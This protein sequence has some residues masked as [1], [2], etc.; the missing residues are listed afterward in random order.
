LAQKGLDSNIQVIYGDATRVDLPE[1]VDVCVS[2]LFGMIASS[3]GAATILNQARR[4]LKPGGVMIPHRCSTQIAAASL[5]ETLVREPRF[6]EISGPYVER[7]FAQMGSPFD[8]RI[9][10]NHFPKSYLLSSSAV[11]EAMD[12]TD[13]A[14]EQFES[15]IRLTITRRGRLDGF[16]LWLTLDTAPGEH[17]DALLDQVHWLPVFFPAFSPGVE[18]DSGDEIRAICTGAPAAG[19]IMPDYLISGYIQRRYGRTNFCFISSR[20]HSE[21]RSNPFYQALFADGYQKRYTMP[22]ENVNP[23]ALEEHLKGKLP[24][25]MIPSTFV[26]V[27]ELPCTASGKLDRRKLE[28]PART[29]TAEEPLVPRTATER[30]VAGIWADLLGLDAVGLDENF[31]D[32]GGHSLLAVRMISRLRKQLDVDAPVVTV[33]QHPTVRLLVS[34]LHRRGEAH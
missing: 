11:F 25:Y 5:P 24:D 34:A 29:R 3:E 17:L 28:M 12:F 31:F 15:E 9:C 14:P 7:V 16:L 4:F 19:T 2:E 26:P 10:I 30:V 13:K 8:I 20:D 33:F 27:T 22:S 23:R 6:T 18:V 1:K 32:L 21:F